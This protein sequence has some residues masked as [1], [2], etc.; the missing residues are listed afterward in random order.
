MQ[1]GVMVSVLASTAVNRELEPWRGQ[2]NDNKM[3]ICCFFPRHAALNSMI[4]DWF[5]LE[6]R[7]MHDLF[8]NI[9]VHQIRIFLS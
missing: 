5:S 8:L 4:K 6:M 9:N 3:S 2:T 1:S 7:I